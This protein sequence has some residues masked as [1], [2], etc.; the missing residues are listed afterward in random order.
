MQI[1]A[2]GLI[3]LASMSANS[4]GFPPHPIQTQIASRFTSDHMIRRRITAACACRAS[5][6]C[7]P[8]AAWMSWRSGQGVTRPVNLRIYSALRP[9]PLQRVASRRCLHFQTRA[10]SEQIR[11]A[12]QIRASIPVNFVRRRWMIP[13]HSVDSQV[14]Q[15]LLESHHLTLASGWDPIRNIS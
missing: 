8:A 15:L 10:P 7:L 2:L 4:V 5:A 12:S 3:R 14:W 6:S 13:P 1:R 9:G 11:E